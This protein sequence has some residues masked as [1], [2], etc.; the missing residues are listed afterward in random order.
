M[1]Q[2]LVNRCAA[3]ATEAHAGQTRRDGVTPYIAHPQR[4]AEAVADDPEA[5]AVA[6]LHDVLED[7]ST[8]LD[9]LEAAGV[10]L[11][12][13]VAVELLTRAPAADYDRYLRAVRTNPLAVRVK[14]ADIVDNLTDAPSPQQVAKY[15]RA[16][17]IL[18][19]V[20][21]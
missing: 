17:E 15:R 2:T 19:G 3:L 7:T 21:G 8:T 9:D 14:I 6:W 10:P 1:I 5:A 11:R 16:L 18:S 20:A 4:V 12:V 13:R